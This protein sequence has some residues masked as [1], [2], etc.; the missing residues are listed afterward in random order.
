MAQLLGFER[1]KVWADAHETSSTNADETRM[2]L[3]NNAAGRDVGRFYS[4]IAIGVR[5][6]R[7]AGQLCLFVG[8]C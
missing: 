5:D 1:A 8:S 3:H 6:F 7:A 2:D 4:D